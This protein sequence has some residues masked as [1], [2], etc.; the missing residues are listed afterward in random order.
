MDEINKVKSISIWIF[1]IPF[2]SVNTCLL[3]IT[4]FSWVISKSRSADISKY[5]SVFRW[6]S[7]SISRTVRPYPLLVIFKPAMFITSFF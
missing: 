6:W 2:I 7:A 5:I 3:I 1:I 4:Q